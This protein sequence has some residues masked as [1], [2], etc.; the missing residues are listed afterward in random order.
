M[1]MQGRGGGG[2]VHVQV[3]CQ[4]IAKDLQLLS[5]QEGKG[6]LLALSA[7]QQQQQ[8]VLSP[9]KGAGVV[10]FALGRG[11]RGVLKILLAGLAG[12]S[13]VSSSDTAVTIHRCV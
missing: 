10:G 2:G 8:M 1:A 13:A 4:H 7:Q 9:F 3:W 11:R 6:L 5:Q 12:A